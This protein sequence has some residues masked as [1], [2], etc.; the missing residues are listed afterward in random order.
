MPESVQDRFSRAHEYVFHLA[1][2]ERY[3]FDPIAAAE[4]VASVRAYPSWAERKADGAAMRRGDPGQSGDHNHGAGVGGN[5]AARNRRS[6]LHINPQPFSAA[7]FGVK[8]VDHYAVFPEKLVEILTLCSTSEAGCCPRCAAPWRRVVERG[9]SQR[10]GGHAGVSRGHADGPMA[11]GGASQWD[12]G[13]MP[14]VRPT[15]T[16]GWQA[17][18]TCEAGPPIGCTV[19]DIFCGSGTTGVVAKRYGRNFIGIEL[20]QSYC[21]LSEKRIASVCESLFTPATLSSTSTG[22]A[23]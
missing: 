21:T 13:H 2:S 16:T 10:M 4:P 19:L 22:A 7:D 5:G 1:K 18:C 17:G 12:A 20:N 3:Y 14:L 9:A 15:I 6:V 23:R 8:D 11:R